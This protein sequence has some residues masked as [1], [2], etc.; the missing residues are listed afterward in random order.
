VILGC[1]ALKKISSLNYSIENRQ[2]V[3]GF[4]E[5][6]GQGRKPGA[7]VVFGHGIG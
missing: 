3:N 6:A 5:A 4:S 1:P 2:Q 7:P